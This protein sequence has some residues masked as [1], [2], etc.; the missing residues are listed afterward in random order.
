MTSMTGRCGCGAVRFEVTQEPMLRVLCHC[1]ICQAFNQAPFADVALVRRSEVH[2][3]GES[4][5]DFQAYRP[6]PN[7]QRGKCRQC[8]DPVVEHLHMPGPL[9]LTFIPSE[10]FAD[11]TQLPAASLRVFYNRRVQDC[12]DTLPRYS[13]YLRSQLGLLRHLSPAL[14][15]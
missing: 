6:P 7:V 12:N 9:A 3:D 10:R 14:L 5:V 13:G 1:T 11:P 4:S 2:V 15:R 8:G